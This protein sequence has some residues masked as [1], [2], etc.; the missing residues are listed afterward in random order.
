MDPDTLNITRLII[1]CRNH[2]R[3]AQKALYQHFYSYC[4]GICMHYAR[5]REDAVEMMNDGFLNV[6]TY[7]NKFDLNRPFKPW[8]KKIMINSAIDHLKKYKIHDTESLENNMIMFSEAEQLDAMS[9]NDLI[10][11]VRKLPPAYRAVFSLHA[12]EGY[13]HEEVAEM[14]NINVG[15]S[16]S[17][18][19]RA[20]MKLQEYLAVYF[21]VK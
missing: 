9:Y 15:T 19:A 14:L 21:E 11:I 17:N 7:I 5:N 12:L 16:K 18:Y 1:D 6:F 13:K 2:K 8:L 10:G 20:L 4:L 3:E